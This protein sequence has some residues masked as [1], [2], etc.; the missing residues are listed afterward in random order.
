MGAGTV[1]QAEAARGEALRARVEAHLRAA[2]GRPVDVMAVT[3][4][5]G[6][7]VQDLLRVDVAGLDAPRYVLR[8]D[9]ARPLPG[10]IDRR[11]ELAVIEAAR[12]VGVRTPAARWPAADLLRPGATALFLDWVDGE[13]IGRKVVASPALALARTRL[14]DEV[15]VELA[16]LHTVTPASCPAL[17][18]ALGAPPPDPLAAQVR[19]LRGLADALRAARPAVEVALAWLGAWLGARP[20]PAPAV[21]A[22]GDLRTGNLVVAPDGLVAV[23]DWEFA[24]WSA[25]EEDL[26]WL[27]VR[28]WRFGQ[29]RLAAGGVAPRE[30]LYRAYEAAAGVAV[31]RDAVRAWEVLGNVRWALGCLAQGARYA[32]RPDLELAAIARRAPEMEWEALRL[33]DLA[34]RGPA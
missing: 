25:R 13:A 22:H 20:A 6:G 3:P 30:A 5:G 10:S 12:A 16:R 1:P 24:R 32:E 29:L 9:A 19:A 26:A 31:D 2:T 11:R 28:D 33:I 17:V 21:L 27:C 14:I 7:A 15:A 8:S 4:L 18:A 23:L 34:E